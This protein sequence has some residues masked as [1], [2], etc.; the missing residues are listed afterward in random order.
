[1]SVIDLQDIL[2]LVMQPSRYLGS[3]IN[4]IK[5]DPGKIKLHVALAF[6][7]LY[8]IG[9]S[10]FGMQIL[11]HILNGHEKIAAERV[12]APGTDV[13]KHLRSA[14][15]PLMSLES[16]RPLP[17]FDIVGFSLLYELNYTNI[18]T[19]FELGGLPFLASQ[20]DLAHPFIIAGGPCTCNPEPIAELFDAIVVGDG[21][22]AIV[23]ISERWL[24]WK[25]SG[26]H[27]KESLLKSW[28]QIEGVYIPGFYEAHYDHRG[29]Q[30]LKP[31]GASHAKKVV[32]TII[33]S[34][35]DAPFPEHPIIPFG[36]PIHDRLRLEIA[37]GCT[38]G[39]RF[40]QAGIIYRPVRERSIQTLLGLAE[41]ALNATGY[42]DLSLLSLSTGDYGKIVSLLERIM[43]FCEPKKIAVSFPSIRAGTLTPELMKLIKSVRKT[44]FTIAPEA[45]SQRLR[46]VIN[47]NISH[48]EI[49]ETVEDAFKMGWQV[50]KLY[51]MIGLPTESEEDLKSIVGLI[52][53]LRKIKHPQ[54]KGKINV[55]VTTF[56]PKPHTSFQWASQL[57]LKESKEKIGW[58]KKQL[59]LP[60]V[61]FKWQNPEVS[62]IEGLW[63]RGDRRLTR[64]LVDAYEKGCKFDGWTDHF[65]HALWKRAIS[66]SAVDIDFYTTRVRN[67]REPLPWDHVDSGI[68]KDFL[69]SEW[70]KAL[71]GEQTSDC[72]YGNCNICGVCDFKKIKP[73]MSAEPIEI[74][75]KHKWPVQKDDEKFSVKRLRITY[76]KLNQAKYFGHLELV[77]IF[78]RALRRAGV[79]LKFSEGFHPL[80][81]IS[82]EDPLPIGME[83]RK[84]VFYLTVYDGVTPQRIA[85]DLN[86]NLP[87]GLRV[88][89]CRAFTRGTVVEKDQI[90]NYLIT[91]KEGFFDEMA[92]NVFSNSPQ[93]ILERT[94][95]KG[96][97]K[98]V[99]L[100]DIVVKLELSAP[101]ILRMA[102]TVKPGIVVRPNEVM[103]EIFGLSD[104]TIKRLRVVK[105]QD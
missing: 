43:A 51:F 79:P 29:F 18:L 75:E 96:K 31:C 55:S 33:K 36:K 60:G 54:R 74:Q 94:N 49:A 11:Y 87:E 37:R 86:A 81:R 61:Q 82:F 83:S 52:R 26:G 4:R 46:N 6:P 13:E 101:K 42:E 98:K 14:G 88:H 44:G 78:L 1:M 103:K 35:D 28:S 66:D 20:R 22:K 89:D 27:E 91:I 40:C 57:S 102:L 7:D 85:E 93:C 19:I 68:T 77:N 72:R 10:H 69:I 73:Q 80:P 9:T 25:E 97:L 99:D 64:L 58:L 38:R 41:R 67:I 104:E 105:Q 8:E 21:E 34:L 32:R 15:I 100:K 17:N 3:E 39:C 45:G 84:E 76:S 47:K 30:S 59:R 71:K 62:Q 5:K 16:H 63:A 50:I 90:T 12:F 24:E 48:H 53:D 56:I 70:E 95:R 23:E 65:N 92:L 2:P